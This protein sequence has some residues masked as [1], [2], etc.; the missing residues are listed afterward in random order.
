MKPVGCFSKLAAGGVALATILAVCSVQAASGRAVARTVKGT[1]S[2]AE[3]GGTWM[4][5]KTGQA[6]APGTTVKTGVDGSVDLFLGDN[7][8]DVHLFDSTTLGLDRLNI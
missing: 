5:L 7:G 6:L 8:P 2:Y 4:P 3:Q 1:A